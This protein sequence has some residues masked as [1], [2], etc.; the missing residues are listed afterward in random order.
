MNSPQVCSQIR[1]SLQAEFTYSPLG[2]FSD[3]AG[4]GV[5]ILTHCRVGCVPSH[6]EEMMNNVS[7]LTATGPV[8]RAFFLILS[9]WKVVMTENYLLLL[10]KW[11]FPVCLTSS[12]WVRQPVKLPG[13]LLCK[14]FKLLKMLLLTSDF[15]N[16]INT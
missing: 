5:Q 6:S 13:F 10:K 8:G 15:K 3:L 7:L 14:L 11:S 16:C 1:T 2:F 12:W 4:L 9:R